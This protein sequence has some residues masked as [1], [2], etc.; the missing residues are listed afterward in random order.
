MLLDERHLS[1]YLVYYFISI[2]LLLILK[3]FKDYYNY[4]FILSFKFKRLLDHLSYFIFEII[5]YVRYYLH[6]D[7][8]RNSQGFMPYFLN[9]NFN[10]I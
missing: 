5:I 8:V 4:Y 10:I 6:I 7:F 9:D 3:L 2:L 1:I